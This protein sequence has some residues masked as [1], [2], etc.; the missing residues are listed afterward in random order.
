MSIRREG[1]VTERLLKWIHE[2]PGA[3]PD[4]A[5]PLDAPIASHSP[6]TRRQAVAILESAIQSRLQI[7]RAHV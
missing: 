6:M 7:G 4:L 2:H 1:P 3:D 5:G